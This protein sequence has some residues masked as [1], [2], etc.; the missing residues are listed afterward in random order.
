MKKMTL[1]NISEE[2]KSRAVEHL[3]K[4]S[5]PNSEFFFMVAMSISMATLGLMLDSATVVI[6]SMLISPIL[7]AFLGLALGI[8]LSD[9]DLI[10]RAIK[11]VGHTTI[12]GII[13]SGLIAILFPTV[14][15]NSEILSSVTPSMGFLVVAI[16][17]GV[18]AA[19]SSMKENL[20]DLL[21]GVAI[22]VSLIPPLA[23]VGIGIVAFDATIARGAFLLFLMNIIGIV[24]GS[25]VVFSLTN[26]YL[27]RSLADIVAKKEDG[28]F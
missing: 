14:T 21:P 10:Y 26:L 3:I 28:D 17:A 9:L 15:L 5:T 6:G 8:V 16:I 24:G 11:T 1:F 25:M 4:V 18:S 23:V 19:Y 22:S 13:F 12:L 27:K 7:Y 20:N 2:D